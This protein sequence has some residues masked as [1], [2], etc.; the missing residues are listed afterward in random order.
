MKLVPACS[1]GMEAA[2]KHPYVQTT[3][4][5]L[6]QDRSLLRPSAMFLK[7]Y[8]SYN[9]QGFEEKLEALCLLQSRPDVNG[10]VKVSGHANALTKTLQNLYQ[11]KDQ[12]NKLS[13]RGDSRITGV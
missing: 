7:Q 12:M 2:H 8:T 1:P 3:V 11:Q 4:A 9:Q 10:T 13:A 6:L 5:I